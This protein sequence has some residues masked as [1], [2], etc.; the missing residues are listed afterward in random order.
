ML[1]TSSVKRGLFKEAFESPKQRN[2]LHQIVEVDKEAD[3]RDILFPFY[4]DI[5]RSESS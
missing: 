5:S 2:H 1:W 4:E 3:L